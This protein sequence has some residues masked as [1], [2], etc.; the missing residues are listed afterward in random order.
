[1]NTT[2]KERLKKQKRGVVR[3]LPPLGEVLR[4]TFIKVYL[5]CIRPNC[6][7][8]KGRKYL[9]GPYYRVSYGKG[10]K[11]NH[12]YVP[13]KWRDKA[14]NWTKNYNILWD[15]I[16]EI[17]KINISLMKLGGNKST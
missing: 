5:E 12:I 10:K 11:V 16:E 14:K 13:L 2:K 7:C 6:K 1:M 3:N 4:G 17:S 8:H 15:A 9:H